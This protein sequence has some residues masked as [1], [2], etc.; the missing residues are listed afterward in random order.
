MNAL[1]LS[2]KGCCKDVILWVHTKYYLL[3]KYFAFKLGL[4]VFKLHGNMNLLTLNQLFSIKL[5][6]E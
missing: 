2:G 3:S 6:C 4:N 1:S 5:F